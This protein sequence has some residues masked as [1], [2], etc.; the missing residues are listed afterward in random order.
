MFF[1][2]DVITV[3]LDQQ[4][5]GGSLNKLNIFQYGFQFLLGE[6]ELVSVLLV[7]DDYMVREVPE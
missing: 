5:L 4:Q 6:V 2:D 1:E 3:S 7:V